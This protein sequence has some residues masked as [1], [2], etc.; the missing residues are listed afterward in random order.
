MQ[1]W[2]KGSIFGGIEGVNFMLSFWSPKYQL[3]S[4]TVKGRGNSLI[5]S[6]HYKNPH[7]KTY[8]CCKITENSKIL[9][10]I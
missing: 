7:S 10:Q 1:T 3:L 5:L 2:H 8:V 4:W 9:R 6:P